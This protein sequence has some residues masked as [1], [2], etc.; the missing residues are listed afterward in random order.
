[1]QSK[2]GYI[3]SLVVGCI[4][5]VIVNGHSGLAGILGGLMFVMLAGLIISGIISIF[6]KNNFQKIFSIVCIIV[7]VLATLGAS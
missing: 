4:A 6:Y 5:S 3:I 7:S 1:M 2:S